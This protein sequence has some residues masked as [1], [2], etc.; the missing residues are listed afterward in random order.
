MPPPGMRVAKVSRPPTRLEGGGFQIRDIMA[1]VPQRALDPFL[2]WHELPRA[3][4]AAG[5]FPGAPMHPHRGFMECPYMREPP[6]GTLTMRAGG[7][8]HANKPEDVRFELG[9]VGV[10]MEHEMLVDP[11]WSGHMHGFQLWVNLPAARKFDAP[12]FH[13]CAPSAL[14]TARL[15]RGASCAVLH[16]AVAGSRRRRAASPSRGCTST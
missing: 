14:P 8:T 15:G 3:R 6:P 2:I 12:H 5:S 11:A 16:G 4:H 1:G 9:K 7:E 13:Q 10:G